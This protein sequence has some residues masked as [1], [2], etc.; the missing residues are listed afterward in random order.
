MRMLAGPESLCLLGRREVEGEAAYCE[1]PYWLLLGWYAVST[2]A[3]SM[4]LSRKLG[5]LRTAGVP[6]CITGD[7]QCR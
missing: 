5:V 2:E 7:E 6:E 1:C 3:V 4:A